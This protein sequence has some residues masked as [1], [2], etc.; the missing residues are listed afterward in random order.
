MRFSWVTKKK[1]RNN[2]FLLP[3]HAVT[4]KKKNKRTT[5]TTTTAANPIRN[6]FFRLFYFCRCLR[7]VVANKIHAHKRV[8]SLF[9]DF[10][11]RRI[12]GR[13]NS[14]APCFR[15]YLS[16][17]LAHSLSLSLCSSILSGHGRHRRSFVSL[18][19][20]FMCFC[21]CSALTILYTVIKFSKSLAL[22]SFSH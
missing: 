14:V 16:F 10:M 21:V 15:F 6:H 12:F 2:F 9:T 22:V 7:V 4:M 19:S 8:R 1:T 18:F 3:P 11:Y 5:T 17:L 13:A 20:P